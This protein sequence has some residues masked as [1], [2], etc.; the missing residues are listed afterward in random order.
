MFIGE[1]GTG[2]KTSLIHR[3]VNNKFD[4]CIGATPGA[5]FNS[6]FIQIDLGIIKLELWDTSGQ[7]KYR[8]INRIFIKGS[9]CVILGY[10][11]TRGKSFENIKKYHYDIVKEIVGDNSLIY[12]VGNKS[13]LYEYEEVLEKEETDYAKEKNIKHFRVSCKEGIGIDALLEDIANSLIIKFKRVLYNND[14]NLIRE[15]TKDG[16]IIKGNKSI[17]VLSIDE[18]KIEKLKIKDKIEIILNKYYNY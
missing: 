18:T 7:E 15:I 8:A 3:I 9:H 16:T 6:I 13:D 10:D 5:N 17:R 4:R 1:A 11:I 12:L 2:A 14:Q